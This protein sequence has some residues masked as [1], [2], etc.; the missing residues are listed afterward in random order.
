MP[1]ILVSALAL[2]LVSAPTNPSRGGELDAAV[3]IAGGDV[4]VRVRHKDGRPAADIQVRLLYARQFTTAASRTDSDGRWLSTV[5]RPGPYEVIVEAE[6]ED[7][8]D[9]RLSFTALGGAEAN[10][11][12]WTTL[13]FGIACL[14]SGMALFFVPKPT[15][16]TRACKSTGVG[17]LASAGV[18]LLG[19]SAWAYWSQATPNAVPVG[20]DVAASTR[21]FLRNREVKPLSEPLERLLADTTKE[22]VKT[23]P[24][25]LLGK[26]APD[27]ELVDHQSQARR[28]HEQ[29]KKGPVVLIFYYG[30]HCNHCVGQL[31]AVHD[32][33]AK[34]RELGAEVIAV[35]ADPPEWTCERFKQYGPF[36]FPVLSDPGNKVAQ[37]Y[38]VFQP[39]VGK[40]PDDLQHGTFVIG[41]DG[42][43]H[44]TQY[45]YEPF[46]GNHTLLHELAKLQGRLPSAQIMDRK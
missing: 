28:L 12:P 3:K 15:F 21:E 29:L 37:V 33:I 13:A 24:H 22:L 35:S 44:W 19:W 36:A 40:T 46:T 11:I 4:E 6:S 30:Y 17:L 39:A 25:P 34:I 9:V 1:W 16:P 26:R 23:H 38:G 41:R 42:L 10:A 45:G 32:D 7:D 27:F 43:V 5:T 18:G 20:P 8:Q 14:I 31:F 2:T